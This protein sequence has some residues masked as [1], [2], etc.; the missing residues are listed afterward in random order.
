MRL[1]GLL[2][3]GLSQVKVGQE[4][5][6]PADYEPCGARVGVVAGVYVM[7]SRGGVEK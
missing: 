1:A 6:T 2:L 4:H 3:K 5:Q 7:D